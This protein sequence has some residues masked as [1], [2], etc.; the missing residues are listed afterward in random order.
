MTYVTLGPT[1]MRPKRPPPP[2]PVVEP[3][4]PEKPPKHHL[5]LADKPPGQPKVKHH[6]FQDLASDTNPRPIRSQTTPVKPAPTTAA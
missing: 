6:S 1:V 4:V 5:D 2:A 3:A